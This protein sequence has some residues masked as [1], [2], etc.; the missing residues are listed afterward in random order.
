MPEHGELSGSDSNWTYTPDADYY[1]EDV[2]NFKVNDGRDDSNEAT[3]TVT[4]TPVNDPP[5]VTIEVPERIALGFPTLVTTNFLDDP[6]DSYEG[7]ADWGDGQTDI[8]GGIV[9]QDGD[10]PRL[11]GV[12]ITEPP[13]PGI[14]GQTFAQH[15]Y[16][17]LGLRTVEFCVTDSDGLAGCDSADIMVESLVSLG[18]GGIVFDGPLAEDEVTKQE[19]DDDATF[20]YELTVLNGQPSISAGLIAQDVVL[21]ME[22]PAKLSIV[23]TTI[24]QGNC[25]RDGISLLCN[26][27]SLSADTS[28]TL[29]LEVVGPGNLI[30]DEAAEVIGLL[31][32][33]SPAVEPEIEFNVNVDLIADIT[34]SDGDGMS[35]A[36][37][38]AFGL[39]PT[40]DDSANDADSDGLDNLREFELRTS[41][42]DIDS[43]GDG[44]PDN[45]EVENGLDPISAADADIDSDFDGFTNLEEF[46]AG[47]DPQSADDFPTIR[48]APVAIFILLGDET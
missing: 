28:V 3:V 44:M 27:G 29:N 37:E 25:S 30:Y 40:G 23:D 22:L 43:D 21:D 13:M 45:F 48:K 41:P 18:F 46:K 15:V 38:A 4:V 6:S 11:E 32:T 35:D 42:L 12:V 17:V 20:T 26:L 7:S 47:T 10:D 33:S 24:S 1:G 5:Q 9:N 39:D 14:E 31:T 34:D 8:T 19:V 16:E 36:F 2:L